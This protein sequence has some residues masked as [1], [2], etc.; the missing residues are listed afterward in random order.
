MTW[1]SFSGFS[2]ALFCLIQLPP[3]KR[4]DLVKRWPRVDLEALEK[5]IAALDERLAAATKEHQR[6]PTTCFG[7]PNWH[8]VV[9]AQGVDPKNATDLLNAL[10]RKSSFVAMSLG[11]SNSVCFYADV[12]TG[13]E[14]LEILKLLK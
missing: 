4:P 2:V 7:I 1:F 3:S 6:A 10:F 14:A 11:D 12:L 5:R 8:T 9:P 13:V